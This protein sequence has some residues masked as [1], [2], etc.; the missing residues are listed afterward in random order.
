MFALMSLALAAPIQFSTSPG[1]EVEVLPVSVPGRV[2]V[3]FHRN[4]VDLRPQLGDDP[5]EGL[6]AWRLSD[7]GGEW[8]LT[9]WMWDPKTSLTLTRPTLTQ[10]ENVWAATVSPIKLAIPPEVPGVCAVDARTALVP[11]HGKDMLHSFPAGLFL[12]AMPRWT[13]GEPEEPATWDKVAAQRRTLGPADA[14][15]NY[16]MGAMHRDL[17]HAREAAYYF[18]TAVKFGA[19]GETALLQAAGAQLASGQWEAARATAA[20]ARLAGAADEP[21]REIEALIALVTLDPE[22]ATSGRALALASTRPAASLVAGGLLLRAG[23]AT[24]AIPVLER[25]ILVEE[26]ERAAMARIL[27]MDAHVLGGDIKGA[28][29]TMKDLSSRGVP[30]RWSGLLRAR[31]RLITLLQQSPNQWAALVPELEKIGRNRDEEGAESLFLLGQIGAAL[32]DARMSIDAWGALVDHHRDLLAGEPGERLAAAWEA[33]VKGLLGDDRELEALAM[34]AGVWRPGLLTH[35]KTAD[36]LQALAVVDERYGL[37]EPA[38]D[39]MKAV[40]DMEGARGLDDRATILNIA[41]LYRLSGRTAEATESLDFLAARPPDPLLSSKATLLRAAVQTDLGQFEA[42]RALYATVSSPQAD[43]DEARVRGA[44]LD[45]HAGRCEAALAVLLAPPKPFPPGVPIAEAEEDAAH[46]LTAL[47]RPV[48]AKA[49]AARAAAA[50]VD[51]DAA[52]FDGWVS[53]AK[54]TAKGPGSVWSRLIAED[55]AH[56]SLKTR[57]TEET[58]SKKEELPKEPTP[59]TDSTSGGSPK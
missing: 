17:G 46:C 57:L 53:R 59:P 19:P 54:D 44:L 47:N 39:L 7:L 45:S 3:I 4:R 1:A 42:A 15:G 6:R 36:Q 58:A 25:A 13:A 50:L 28:E 8:V 32:G 12:P 22:P 43:A 23:C 20:A 38:L 37:F 30:E 27:L 41:R 18:A 9:A 33:R 29:S 40:S 5:I 14:P 34:H 49:A 26:S 51:A 31:A 2:E 56:G 35:L 52:A 21:V 55:T 11:L 24:E 48:E 16:A 10:T